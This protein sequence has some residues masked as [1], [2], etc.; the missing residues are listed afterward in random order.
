MNFFKIST[1]PQNPQRNSFYL[2]VDNWNDYGYRTLFKLIY[3]DAMLGTYD[4]GS[5]KIGHASMLENSSV[6]DFIE[7]SFES[8]DENFFSLGQDETYYQNIRA[9]DKEFGIDI[10]DRVFIALRD[11]A[12]D[13]SIFNTFSSNEILSISLLRF[14]SSTSVKGVL[15]RI[16]QGHSQLTEY[17]FKFLSRE[18]SLTLDFKVNPDSSLRSNIH[19]LVGRNG[20]GKTRLLKNMVETYISE[21]S[22]NVFVFLENQ[23]INIVG[24]RDNFASLIFSSFSA[25]DNHVLPTRSEQFHKKYTYI[26]LFHNPSRNKKSPAQLKNIDDLTSDFTS[27]LEI[28]RRNSKLFEW[29][30]AIKTLESDP[31]FRALDFLTISDLPVNKMLENAQI[32]F[33]GL[34]SGHKIVLLTITKLVE[35]VQE[36][37]LVLLDEPECH[38][39]PPLLSAFI[40][41]LSRLL[42]AKN[43]V[44]IVATHSP[45]IL[46]QV[47]SHCVSIISRVGSSTKAER[48]SIN[49]FGG[50]IGNLTNEIFGL[51][52]TES[53]FYLDVKDLI[54]EH[55]N[56]ESL[57]DS[58]NNEMGSVAQAIAI[59]LLI[60]RDKKIDKFR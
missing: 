5:V 21:H 49:T 50:S 59:S 10:S 55:S 42:S 44:A 43:A 31:N 4:L 41:A 17:E 39:H 11:C 52:V 26:G 48:P 56:I 18:D 1:F 19:V 45:V 57:N 7:P 12:Y 6:S 32:M 22:E 3:F 14:L 2:V 58:T 25:F 46:Q 13:N 37:S 8:L 35:C 60:E 33:T 16:S 27:S 51:E 29:R 28:C 34:S 23:K 9:L 24:M 30:R 54:K 36:K 15:H 20:S 40:R 53:G 47:P 38:L